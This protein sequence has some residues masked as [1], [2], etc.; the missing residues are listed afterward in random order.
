[1]KFIKVVGWVSGFKFQVMGVTALSSSL[2]RRRFLFCGMTTR[3]ASQWDGYLEYHT[4]W[5]A[6]MGVEILFLF[7]CLQ[8]TRAIKKKKIVADSG[9][10][11]LYG[12]KTGASKY[13]SKRIAFTGEILVII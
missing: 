4:S 10:R 6:P 8:V 12:I 11:S 7:C 1:V 5:L 9:T 13:Y 2:L 3:G